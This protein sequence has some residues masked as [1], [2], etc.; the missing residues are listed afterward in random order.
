[1]K[2]CSGTLLVLVLSLLV[3]ALALASL[4][5]GSVSGAAL[6]AASIFYFSSAIWHTQLIPIAGMAGSLIATLLVYLLAG[7]SVGITTLILAG[8]AVNALAARYCDRLYLPDRGELKAE[9]N[10]TTVLS[11]TNIREVFGVDVITD[12]EVIPWT[13][14]HKLVTNAN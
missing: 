12:C 14:P 5:V 8:V 6:G 9:G 3:S 13:V 1:M 11:N 10:A 4:T 7:R 2:V